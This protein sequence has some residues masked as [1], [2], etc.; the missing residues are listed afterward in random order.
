MVVSRKS[1]LTCMGNE[2][3][4]PAEI[5]NE[6]ESSNDAR[7]GATAVAGAAVNVPPAMDINPA[8]DATAANRFMAVSAPHTD[9][10]A[11][12]S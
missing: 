12:L 7:C 10:A 6:K 1:S 2:Q 3:R 5:T 4:S 9:A 11:G 8:L